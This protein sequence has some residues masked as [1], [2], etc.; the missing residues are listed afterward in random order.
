[1]TKVKEKTCMLRSE[2]IT[3]YLTV[4]HQTGHQKVVTIDSIIMCP[5]L[6]KMFLLMYRLWTN[7]SFLKR[8]IRGSKSVK[9]TY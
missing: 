5:A 8:L 6:K 3:V 4:L 9:S 2:L 1:M 7:G